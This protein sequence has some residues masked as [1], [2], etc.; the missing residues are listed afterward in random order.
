MSNKNNKKI[1]TAIIE[2]FYALDCLF[3]GN[4]HPKKILEGKEYKKYVKVKTIALL[5]LYEIYKTFNIGSNQSYETVSQLREYSYK[6]ASDVLEHT[7]NLLSTPE[8]ISNLLRESANL[9]LGPYTLSKE[10]AVNYVAKRKLL[11]SSVDRL[12]LGAAY[13]PFKQ[14]LE[15]KDFKSN[16]LNKSYEKCKKELIELVV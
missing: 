2:N 10:H 4:E 13:N 3:F 1:K 6:I 16:V 14:K 11:S 12:L 8:N 5:N 9:D 7:Q 15:K